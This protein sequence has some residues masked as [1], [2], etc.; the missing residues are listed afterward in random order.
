[1]KKL[2]SIITILTLLMP[3]ASYA[4]KTYSPTTMTLVTSHG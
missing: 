1:M 4:L 3:H 2:K